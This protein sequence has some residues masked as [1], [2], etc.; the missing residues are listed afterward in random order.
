MAI[1]LDELNEELS[2][3]LH[4]RFIKDQMGNKEIDELFRIESLI[5]NRL[6]RTSG[7][8]NQLFTPA[9]QSLVTRYLPTQAENSTSTV[10][11]SSKP[12]TLSSVTPQQQI[13]KQQRFQFQFQLAH[14]ERARAKQAREKKEQ[15]QAMEMQQRQIQQAIVMQ[16]LQ[17]KQA[18]EMQQ[19]RLRKKRLL[20][21]I[22]ENK[23]GV[24]DPVKYYTELARKEA[25]QREE[26]VM[27]RLRQQMM[28]QH[29]QQQR[30]VAEAKQ[31]RQNSGFQIQ[32]FR[33]E[34]D[35]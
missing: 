29:L 21:D 12:E 6:S 13:V 18:V 33:G 25:R 27:R 19:E 5:K 24:Q 35:G 16:H 23:A 7:S 17:I 4:V 1:T 31:R 22:R 8:R 28:M 14:L 2:R 20:Q 10:V 34:I 30:I 15:Q 9:Y 32:R 11:A 3:E 26:Q